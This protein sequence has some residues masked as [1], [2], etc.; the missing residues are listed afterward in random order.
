MLADSLEFTRRDL[1]FGQIFQ[2]ISYSNTINQIT[3]D[4]TVT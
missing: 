4:F 2:R 1:R 3:D